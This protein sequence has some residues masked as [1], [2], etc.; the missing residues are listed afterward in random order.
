[1]VFRTL[2]LASWLVALLFLA[3]REPRT[4][5]LALVLAALW[6]VA[7]LRDRRPVRSARLGTRPAGIRP[8]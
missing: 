2:V 7:L 4:L 8:S 1:M 6:T 5:L 3:E